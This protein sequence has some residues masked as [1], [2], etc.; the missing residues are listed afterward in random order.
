MSEFVA[1]N[2]MT[3]CR[4]HTD[5]VLI[6]KGSDHVSIFMAEGTAL[7]LREF[8]H[9]ERDEE[10]GRWRSPEFPDHAVYPVPRTPQVVGRGVQVLDERTGR[11]YDRWEA[12]TAFNQWDTSSRE[13]AARAYFEAH[14]EMSA[15]ENAADGEIWE[16]GKGPHS[17]Q[18]LVDGNRFFR[19]PLVSPDSPKWRPAYF[20]SELENGR[21]IWPEDAS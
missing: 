13:L 1:S 6:D 21:R 4:D 2:G 12:P 18:C 10:L 7:A 15:W 17:V 14:P 8:F 11:L 16:F 3:V 5:D 19:L 20:A 9:H